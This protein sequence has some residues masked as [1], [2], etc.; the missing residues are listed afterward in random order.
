MFTKIELENGYILYGNEKVLVREYLL[1]YTNPVNKIESEYKV[2]VYFNS[3]IDFKDKFT[4]E[5]IFGLKM[6]F[7]TYND[8]NQ[9]AYKTIAD[10]VIQ[11]NEEIKQIK[12]YM[13]KQ[14]KFKSS[15]ET[16]KYGELKEK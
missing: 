9:F 10:K 6:I 14:K 5:D 13:E 4:V 11:Q 12:T 15:R 1:K 8:A 3:Q 7:D 2:N 16:L